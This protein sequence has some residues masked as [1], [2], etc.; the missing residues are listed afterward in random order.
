MKPSM[1]SLLIFLITTVSVRPCFSARWTPP[2]AD[3]PTLKLGVVG[4]ALNLDIDHL[5]DESPIPVEYRPNSVGR[6]SVGVEYLGFGA[7]IGSTPER[8]PIQEAQFGSTKGSDY[9]F[10]FLREQNSFDLFYQKYQGFYILNSQQIE[11]TRQSTDPY[12]QRP[13][14][15]TEHYGLQYFRTLSPEEFSMASCFEQSGWQKES[16]GTWFFYGGVDRHRIKADYSLIPTQVAEFFP[17]IKDF[18]GGEFTTAKLGFGGAYALIYNNFFAAMKLIVAGGQQQQHYHLN[19][20]TV[21]RVLPSSG[22]NAKISMGYNGENYF[23]SL[24]VFL[25]STD[26]VMNDGKLKMGTIETSIFW[27][28]HL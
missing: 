26:L 1:M 11:P 16:G 4:T 2:R 22:G 20:E 13:D 24:N 19:S 18:T 10:R 5:E 17:T 3:K 25:D 12:L 14:L 21:D 15:F 7:T 9:Q 6:W 8:N 28:T 27:G 23:G